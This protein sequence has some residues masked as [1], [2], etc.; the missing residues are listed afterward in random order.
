MLNGEAKVVGVLHGGAQ[1]SLCYFTSL[2]N[3]RNT[4]T[5][6]GKRSTLHLIIR[7]VD[8]NVIFNS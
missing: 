2:E 6:W 3:V 8:S 4:M 7:F 1:S 5:F